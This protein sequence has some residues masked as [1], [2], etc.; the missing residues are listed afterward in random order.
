MPRP[1]RRW[2]IAS[3][4]VAVVSLTAAW[5]VLGTLPGVPPGDPPRPARTYDEAIARV[6]SIRA[7]EGAGFN[8]ACRSRVLATGA[9]TDRA[10]VLLH[11][12]TN[13]PKQFE[14]IADDLAAQGMNVYVPLLPRHGRADRMTD[15]LSRLTAEELVRAGDDAVDVARG[16]GDR[17]TVVGLSSSGVLTAWLAEHRRDIDGAVMIAPALGPH[18]VA[19][20]EARR[21]TG[22]LLRVPDFF[23]WWDR[24]RKAASPGPEQCYPR[25]ASRALAQI[26]R[27][28]F[29]VTD[30]AARGDPPA[31]RLALITSA[32]DEG[33]D[34][35]AAAELARRWRARGA[36]V[37]A[38]QFPE[39]L[40]VRHDMIDPEQPY[41]KVAVSYPVIEAMI[42]DTA[43]R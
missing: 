2:W 36:D 13:C 24:E 31:A 34:N 40:G 10:V 28:G 15:A 29:A 11:G 26:Y 25:F 41:Q 8:P 30:R 18:G 1:T 3:A 22:L 20:P 7:R 33:I 5:L 38:Y 12:F 9:R 37:R 21:M 4:G 43:S 19:A 14:R 39:S 35:R 16:L 23:V 42:R 27:L 6:D 32:C 17:V